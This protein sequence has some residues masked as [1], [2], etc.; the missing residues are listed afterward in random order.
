MRKN[1]LLF[2]VITPIAFWAWIALMLW[3]TGAV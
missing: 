3:V 2:V 1:E